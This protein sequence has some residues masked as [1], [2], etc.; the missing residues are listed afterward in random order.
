[1]YRRL[2]EVQAGVRTGYVENYSGNSLDEANFLGFTE[3][4]RFV[5]SFT[6]VLIVRWIIEFFFGQRMLKCC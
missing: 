4:E 3:F 1:M 6:V 5:S 2:E